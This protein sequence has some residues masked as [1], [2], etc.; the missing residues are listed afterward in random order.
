MIFV[1][2]MAIVPTSRFAKIELTGCQ[3]IHSFFNYRTVTIK[4]SSYKIDDITSPKACKL[5]P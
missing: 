5:V 1:G 4:S 3:F 2:N